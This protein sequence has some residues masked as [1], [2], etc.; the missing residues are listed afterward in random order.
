M[1]VIVIKSI[2]QQFPF[3]FFESDFSQHLLNKHLVIKFYTIYKMVI[4]QILSLQHVLGIG[5][6]ALQVRVLASQHSNLNSK[7]QDL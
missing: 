2:V 7:S 3:S 4:L 1:I 6:M 5:E